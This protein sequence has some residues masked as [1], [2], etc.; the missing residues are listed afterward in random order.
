[1]VQCFFLWI[2]S[3]K[4]LF[5]AHLL[6]LFI[7]NSMWNSCRWFWLD[8][9]ASFHFL[10]FLVVC[11]MDLMGRR[12]Y[13]RLH[14]HHPV[15]ECGSCSRGGLQSFA[16]YS[17]TIVSSATIVSG[18]WLEQYGF[19]STHS[20]TSLYSSSDPAPHARCY[21]NSSCLSFFAHAWEQSLWSTTWKYV[22]L[23]S[24]ISILNKNLFY[25]QTGLMMRRPCSK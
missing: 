5:A 1:M 17:G 14:Q 11:C 7:W 8:S 10:V 13:L 2:F 21:C 20:I 9:S 23:Y 4:L 3:G 24:I 19:L 18:R 25:R 15:W 16:Y 22:Y 12:S 6:L